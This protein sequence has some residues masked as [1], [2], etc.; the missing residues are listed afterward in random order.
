VHVLQL[1][2]EQ[3][4]TT[5]IREIQQLQKRHDS[6]LQKLEKHKSDAAVL[7]Q[8]LLLN[9]KAKEHYAKDFRGLGKAIQYLE[10][11]NEA[12]ALQKK[13]SSIEQTDEKQA[14]ELEKL[15]I[16]LFARNWTR[17]SSNLNAI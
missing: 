7:Q 13:L 11:K 16:V 12:E 17:T 4:L 8:K 3:E 10:K 5:I 6:D 9:V 14:V 2:H 15:Q 1:Q